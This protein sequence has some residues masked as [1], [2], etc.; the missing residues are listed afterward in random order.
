[1]SLADDLLGVAR[2]MAEST[3]PVWQQA[4]LRRA[5]STAYY[6]LFHLLV[7]EA[8]ARFVDDPKIRTLVARGFSHTDLMKVATTFESG[9]GAL[10]KHIK[11]VFADAIPHGIV[12]ISKVF[13][14]LQRNRHE[15]DYD[16]L[17]VFV[18]HEV[19]EIV[20]KAEQAF[21]D[22]RTLLANPAAKSAID[23]FLS[24]LLLIDR[25]KK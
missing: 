9:A 24:S 15:A 5:A 16:L 19:V 23:L 4:R 11:L 21:A 12:E 20:S 14:L 2:E 18:Q 13:I 6:A 10:P 8:A 17:S 3:N 1:M 22:F 25:W 7:E